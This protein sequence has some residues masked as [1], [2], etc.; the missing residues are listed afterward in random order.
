MGCLLGV[1]EL[2][3]NGRGIVLECHSLFHTTYLNM[4]LPSVDGYS[5]LERLGEG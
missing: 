1:M 2:P 3:D 4:N 5:N